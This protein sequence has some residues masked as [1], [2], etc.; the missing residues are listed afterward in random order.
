M[1]YGLPDTC[2]MSWFVKASKLVFSISRP[3][4]DELG[5]KLCKSIEI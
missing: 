3:L 4:R 2:K 1:V 5:I